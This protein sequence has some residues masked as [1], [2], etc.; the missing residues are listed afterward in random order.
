[1]VEE[2]GDFLLFNNLGKTSQCSKMSR[3]LLPCAVLW[4]TV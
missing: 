3:F 1:V 2:V 4:Q